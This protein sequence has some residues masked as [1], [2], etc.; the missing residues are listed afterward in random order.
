MK[1]S[2][3]VV[4]IT[5]G[6]ASGKSTAGKILRENGYKVVE[7]DIIVHQLYNKDSE[8]YEKLIKEFGEEIAGEKA[9]N[10]KTLGKIVFKDKEK[11]RKLN[12]IVH[13]YV[14][15]ELI[16]K[17]IDS[18]YNIV[19]LDIPLMIEEREKLKDYG[20]FYDE[21]WLIKAKEEIR[22][23][24]I[25]KRDNLSLRES[26]KIINNQMKDSEKEKYA[27][28]VIENNGNTEELVRNINSI[29]TNFKIEKGLE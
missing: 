11:L 13:K 10:R 29:L 6:I 12:D 7:S 20:L 9:I 16:R 22:I 25:R 5:G 14:V 18:D 2:N 17:S 3:Q 28:R 4:V 23:N 19:F 24:R 1:R 15:E 27:D 21:I 26:K 8:I